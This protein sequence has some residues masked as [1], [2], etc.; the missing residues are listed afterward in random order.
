M[1]VPFETA[2]CR[3]SVKPIGGNTERRRARFCKNAK[4]NYNTYIPPGI[5]VT[6]PDISSMVSIRIALWAE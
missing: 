6:N 1:T 2:A 4:K 3:R 5:P